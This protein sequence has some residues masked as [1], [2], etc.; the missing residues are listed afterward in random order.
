VQSSFHLPIAV[1]SL[2]TLWT[3]VFTQ[4]GVITLVFAA[5]DRVWTG[6]QLFCD[7]DPRKLPKVKLPQASKRRLN[8]AAGAVFGILG[9]FWLLAVP[10]FPFLILG[11]AA[12][13]L[14]SAPIWHSVY[15]PILVLAI[16]GVVENAVTLIRPDIGW[17]RPVFRVGTTAF[18]L[19]IA[20][21]LLQTR[22][23]LVPV[24]QHGAQ[25]A[26]IG[27]LMV[28]LCVA[29]TSLGLTIALFFEIWRAVQAISHPKV[30]QAARVA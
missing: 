30:S 19:W 8:A 7:W 9:I 24:Y 15:V 6:S 13:Y 17:F 23:Y 26:A 14:K 25:A 10:N 22:T 11:P 20:H 29:G 4:F 2:G 28:L 3:I 1:G 5:I 16:A 18:S 21:T 12:F 27:N